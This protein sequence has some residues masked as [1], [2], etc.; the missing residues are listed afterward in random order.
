MTSL[1]EQELAPLN[2]QIEQIRE[3]REMLKEQLGV[4]AA[5]LEKFSAARQRFDALQDVCDALDK[6]A[7]L[8]A[9]KLFWKGIPGEADAAGHLERIR[10]RVVRFEQKISEIDEKQARLQAQIDRRN[11]ELAY[12]HEEV[13]EAYEREERRREEFVIERE[14]S[15]VPYRAMIMPW[16]KADRERKALSPHSSCG[17][18]HL[19]FLRH[20]YSPGERAATGLYGRCGSH[21]GTIGQAGQEGATQAVTGAQ[22]GAERARGRA[23]EGEG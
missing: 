17:T 11:D 18:A 16:T 4:V 20:S 22:A 23:P 10:G 1:L 5:E 12:L 9:G 6:L 7:E 19:H 21:T 13:Q 2:A 8:E 15:P 14:I 3:K